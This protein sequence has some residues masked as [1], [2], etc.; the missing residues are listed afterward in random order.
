MPET[1][2]VH[3]MFSPGLSLEFLC[4]ELVIFNEQ[5]VILLWVIWCKN[6]SFWQRF[7]CNFLDLGDTEKC[8]T[9]LEM[10]DKSDFN[11]IMRFDENWHLEET[12]C[13]FFIFNDTE[14]C[15]TNY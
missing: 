3:N 11:D 1:I 12:F 14:K 8:L 13:N 7:T 15:L 5:S 6:K 10:A 2:S 4:I 9:N